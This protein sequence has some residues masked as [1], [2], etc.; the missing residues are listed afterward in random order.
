MN[1]EGWGVSGMELGVIGI[2]RDL[3]LRGG[4]WRVSVMG[5]NVRRGVKC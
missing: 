5:A 1:Q 4:V 2:F 3:V